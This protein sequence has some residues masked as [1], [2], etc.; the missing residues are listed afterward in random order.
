M[1]VFDESVAHC[2]NHSSFFNG[3]S[4]CEIY[5]LYQATFEVR[6]QKDLRMG[7]HP[8][9][10]KPGQPGPKLQLVQQQTARKVFIFLNNASLDV[11]NA[12]GKKAAEL[13]KF[14]KDENDALLLAGY[15][16]IL[17]KDLTAE[18]VSDLLAAQEQGGID[19]LSQLDI[20]TPAAEEAVNMAAAR[21]AADRSAEMIGKKWEDG[22]LVDSPKARYVISDTTMDDLRDI[23]KEAL[24][25]DLPV[26][27]LQDAV[28]TAK[29]FSRERA[30]L[31][32]KT[33]IAMAQVQGH[34]NTWKNSGKIKSVNV[35]LSDT[36]KLEDQC[37][38]YASSG[39]YLIHEVP[40]IPLH[41]NCSCSIIAAELAA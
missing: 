1:I 12:I 26:S 16:S 19:A 2:S 4:D 28:K 21:Y 32:A 17:W 36:H 5:L 40:Q 38:S 11:S 23:I 41:P 27:G 37:D 30:E 34:L 18:I 35:V 13:N 33:E 25:H 7:I 14:T 22:Q 9:E 29:T 24:D 6:L 20:H 31:I 39:P 15:A 8:L 3:C 10:I